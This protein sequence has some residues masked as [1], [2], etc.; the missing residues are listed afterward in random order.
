VRRRVADPDEVE[1]FGYTML[2]DW[3]A[4]DLQRREMKVGLGPIKGKDAAITL[5]PWLVTADAPRSRSASRKSRCAS[6]AGHVA[7]QHAIAFARLIARPRRP[8]DPRS[9]PGRA[10]EV[11][12][13]QPAP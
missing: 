6:T 11:Q 1:I 2:N 10:A 3:S 13:R 12:N 9:L 4:R 8:A 5:G 7:H